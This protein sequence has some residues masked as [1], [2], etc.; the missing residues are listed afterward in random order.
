MSEL[1][2]A[3]AAYAHGN[4][5]HELARLGLCVDARAAEAEAQR[6]EIEHR[7]MAADVNY[8]SDLVDQLRGRPTAA[9]FVAACAISGI[10]GA[11]MHAIFG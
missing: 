5:Q 10:V 11:S 9:A 8:L 7:R 4:H 3:A 6:R 2:A 1:K